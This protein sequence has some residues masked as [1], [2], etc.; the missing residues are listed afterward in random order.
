MNACVRRDE[1]AIHTR[2]GGSVLTHRPTADLLTQGARTPLS[3]LASRK[4]RTGGL[5]A[6]GVVYWW[7][8]M[9]KRRKKKIWIFTTIML[10]HFFQWNT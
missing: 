7:P 8:E 5:V 1:A 6:V 3:S 9:R 10:Y 4:G 2:C